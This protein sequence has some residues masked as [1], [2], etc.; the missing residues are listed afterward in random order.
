MQGLHI[1]LL[2]VTV[3]LL[4][5]FLCNF[6][7]QTVGYAFYKHAKIGKNLPYA[8]VHIQMNENLSGYGFN[9]DTESDAVILY[10]GGSD[11]VAYN[12]VGNF[13]GLF[14]M[15][16]LSADYYGSRDSKGKMN[17]KT[18]QKTATDFYDYAVGKYPDKKFI[19]IGHSYGAGIAVYLA[20]V[21]NCDKLFIAAAYRDLSDLYNK[22]IPIF[23]G[24]AKIFISNNIDAK[25]YAKNVVC[26]TYVIG[27]NGDETLSAALQYKVKDCFGLSDIKIFDGITHENYFRTPEVISYVKEK[28]ED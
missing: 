3:I 26:H 17:L 20:S 7:M 18:M 28:I 27:S 10:F 24:P 23:W 15:P 9:L 5:G 4:T 13:G 1:A 25:E 8:P 19:V 22:M 6:V 21:R 2:V 16:F 12:S 14:D 11:Y